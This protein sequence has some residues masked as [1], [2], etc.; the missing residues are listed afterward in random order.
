VAIDDGDAREPG[1]CLHRAGGDGG[2][3]EDAESLAA[4]A[5]RVVGAAG[6]VRRPAASQSLTGGG[7]RRAARLLRALHH[8]LRPRKADRL[9]LSRREIPAGDPLEIAR[10]MRAG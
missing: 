6:E 1:L 3:V 8:A 5:E 9:H 10:A 4:I 7:E 2:V